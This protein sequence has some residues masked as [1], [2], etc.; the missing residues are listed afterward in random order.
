MTTRES[1]SLI[2]GHQEPSLWKTNFGDMVKAQAAK[3][4]SRPAV[5]VPWQSFRMSYAELADR[6]GQV[7]VTLLD[8]GLQRGDCVGIMAGNRH[9]YIEIALGAFRI[10]CPVVLLNNNYS[11][12]EL[13]NAVNISCE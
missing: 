7:A 1:L 12:G 5:V 13:L 10:G 9:E 4:S 2:S 6:S 3:Y 11:P 8:L